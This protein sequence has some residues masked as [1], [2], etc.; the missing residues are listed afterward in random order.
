MLYKLAEGSVTLGKLHKSPRNQ[1]SVEAGP[2]AGT[3]P[4]SL[5]LLVAL[6]VTD[7]PVYEE[8]E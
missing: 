6:R 5:Q 1:D 8:L 4:F 7:L 3:S 2:G